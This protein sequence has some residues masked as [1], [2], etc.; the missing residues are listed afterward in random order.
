[1]NNSEDQNAIESGV[2]TNTGIDHTV[3][4]V[5]DSATEKNSDNQTPPDES[6]RNEMAMNQL[7]QQEEPEAK[8]YDALH[9]QQEQESGENKADAHHASDDHAD[10]TPEKQP[11]AVVSESDENEQQT[12]QDQSPATKH[13][14]RTDL[15]VFLSRRAEMRRRHRQHNQ[16]QHDETHTAV[17]PSQTD[18]FENATTPANPQ[19]NQQIDAETSR[20]ALVAQTST[21]E[22]AM[23]ELP[24]S[25]APID[26]VKQQSSDAAESEASQSVVSNGTSPSTNSSEE[27]S[28]PDVANAFARFKSTVVSIHNRLQPVRSASATGYQ[29]FRSIW[30]KRWK[31]S[32]VLYAVVFVLLTAAST[33]GLQWGVYSEPEYAEGSE[34]DNATKVAQSVIGQLTH[35]V[36]K[37]WLEHQFQFLL[38]FLVLAIVY[39][40]LV[41]V[42]NRFWVSTAIFGSIMA[43]YVIANSFKVQLRNE[44]IIP[45]DLNF[46]SGGNTGEIMSFVSDDQM[47]F[48]TSAMHALLWFIA[49]CIVLQFLDH[50]NA[51]IPTYWK[52]PIAHVKNIAGNITRVVAVVMSISL[53]FSFTWNIN[54]PNSRA[55]NWA[56][57]LD[58]VPI[59]F[60]AL[61]DARANGTVMSFTRLIHTKTMNAPEDYNQET[62]RQL[63]KRYQKEATNI[64]ATR[65]NK[66]TDSTVIAILSESFSDP[67]RVPGVQ[68]TEDPMPNIRN[69]K[70]ETTSGLML[71]TGYGGGTANMEYQA[72][73]GLSMANYEPTLSI[74]YQQLVPNEK[75][76]PTF[77]Q[78]WNAQNGSHSSLAVHPFNSGMYFRNANYKKF[79]FWKFWAENGDNKITFCAALDANPYV[80][81][82]CTY[83][84]VLMHLS[85]DNK[86]NSGQFIQTVTMQNHLPFADWYADNQFKQ[87][88][89]SENLSEDEHQQMQAY[90]KGV[91][92]TDQ[93]TLDFLKQLDQINRPITVVFYGDHLPSIYATASSDSNNALALHE[94]DYFIWSNAASTSANTKLPDDETQYTSSNYFMSQAAEHMNAKV[95]P[96]L[97]FLTEMHKQIPAMSIPAAAGAENDTPVYLDANGNRILEK[98]LSKKAK[99]MLHDYQLIQYDISVGKNYLKDTDFM[100][101][102]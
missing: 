58:D 67:T 87:A 25:S 31:F 79:G 64:N 48:V 4:P 8:A 54:T 101:L 88:D 91:N 73:T 6:G 66:Y 65:Q 84:N 61:D 5:D 93:A 42:V 21:A 23:Q 3:K 82:Q 81:D 40:T 15:H 34:I 55:K 77:N 62:I 43:V 38:N 14:E 47:P 92:N 45:A 83:N 30:D 27:T 80:S 74:A 69:I 90:A 75:W 18:T 11:D 52:H 24:Q 71:S 56:T 95:S 94:T 19:A 78:L 102:P 89:I 12:S 46:V 37:I 53:L 9:E 28:Q 16:P 44:P 70:N 98:D 63:A 1:M 29:K 97:A 100:A 41:V 20:D 86:D 35:F 85:T 68:L 17:E 57:S 50:R 51:F 7:G 96:Y 39:L 26:N 13:H 33:I 76:T 10:S 36:S 59:L 49:I 22:R 72:L 99:S 2:E 60:N 32:Y